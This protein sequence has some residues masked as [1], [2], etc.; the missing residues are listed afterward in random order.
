[1][2]KGSAMLRFDINLSM[3][4]TDVPLLQRFQRAADLGFG[5]VELFWP[6][7]E[8]LAAVVAAKEAASVE[9]VLMNM[10]TGPAGA[11]G[12][13][14]DPDHQA[15]WR[16]AFAAALELATRLHCPRIHT[17]AGN[18][19][20]DLPRS[21]QVDCAVENLAGM[22][23]QM[24]AAG[25][26]ALVEALNHFDNPGFLVTQMAD[27]VEICRGVGS[28]HVRA[29]FDVYHMQ[30]MQGNLIETFRANQPWI[31]HVQIADTPGR[32]QPGTGEIH[33][34]HVLAA[35][36]EAEYTGYVGLEYVP[37]GTLEEAL[38]WLPKSARKQA[39]AADLRL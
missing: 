22:I 3:T 30:R 23:P 19:R 10:N 11:R 5:A 24:E 17:V 29:Q 34:R 7:D 27:M 39:T 35:L 21:V 31:G 6:G 1:M 38:A 4:L 15:W 32:H 14:S 18:R 25:V 8:D 36:E 20:P 12:L 37:H 9:V 26:T 28:P 13:L 2:T 16:D 33:Y